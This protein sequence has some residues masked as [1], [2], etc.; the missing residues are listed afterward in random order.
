MKTRVHL[1]NPHFFKSWAFFTFVIVVLR[2]QRLEDPKSSLANQS[3]PLGE[4]PT[5]EEHCF[6]LSLWFGCWRQ[7]HYPPSQLWCFN[8]ASTSS[9]F[10]Y[11]LNASHLGLMA[12]A[13]SCL[14]MVWHALCRMLLCRERKCESEEG[15]ESLR[16][17]W[18]GCHLVSKRHFW[19]YKA[20]PTLPRMAWV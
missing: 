6:Y 17:V 1:Q 18:K 2:K 3:R 15:S 7:S 10:I 8:Q 19:I 12:T 5:N 14:P 16:G 11:S 13:F 4:L 20:Q 9:N